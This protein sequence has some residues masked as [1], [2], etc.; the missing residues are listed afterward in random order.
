MNLIIIFINIDINKKKDEIFFKKSSLT[1]MK[2]L[3]T[4]QL[5]SEFSAVILAEIFSTSDFLAVRVA[6]TKSMLTILCCSFCRAMKAAFK[7][8]NL[9]VSANFAFQSVRAIS[10]SDFQAMRVTSLTHRSHS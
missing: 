4:D 5:F 1:E 6:L 8:I 2:D 7:N 3:L 9:S 10:D